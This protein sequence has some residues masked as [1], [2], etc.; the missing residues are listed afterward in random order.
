MYSGSASPSSLSTIRKT[1][2]WE[3]LQVKSTIDG[4][5]LWYKDFMNKPMDS[6][7]TMDI[8]SWTCEMRP[9]SETDKSYSSG[10]QSQPPSLGDVRQIVVS[11][12]SGSNHIY[13]DGQ[14]PS[15]NDVGRREP[16]Q[17]DAS[18]NQYEDPDE[19]EVQQVY[20]RGVAGRSND[21]NA[22]SGY[23]EIKQDVLSNFGSKVSQS[24]EIPH[25]TFNSTDSPIN[26]GGFLNGGDWAPPPQQFQRIGTYI[27]VYKSGAIA[28]L[29][30]ISAYS[31]YHELKKDLARI[32]GIEGQLDDQQRNSWKL[33]FVDIDED[34]LIVGDDPW[35]EFVLCVSY[36]KILSPQE[37][38]QMSL[39]GD[40]GGNSV[41]PNQACGSFPVNF[42]DHISK[43]VE[44]FYR[45]SL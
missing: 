23:N 4:Q 40:F 13:S 14:P 17:S 44:L 28:R 18:C 33:V 19:H 26:D 39:D 24:F 2:Y 10:G 41:T 27:M 42:N 31:G 25:M 6:H 29:I 35:Q 45:Q 30:D 12:P 16:S 34:V 7:A 38:Q 21:I 43:F 5:P 8:E 9:Q 37:V 36:I 32:F 11:E 3:Q 22:S 1:T 20:K 15:V